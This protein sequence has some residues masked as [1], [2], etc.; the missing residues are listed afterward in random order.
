V[1]NALE[2]ALAAQ[3]VSEVQPTALE[4]AQQVRAPSPEEGAPVQQNALE[5]ALSA[6]FPEAPGFAPDEG[7]SIY[8]GGTWKRA[9]ERGGAQTQGLYGQFLRELGESTGFAGLVDVGDEYVKKAFLEAVRNP[10]PFEGL[11]DL[12][13]GNAGQFVLNAIGEQVYNLGIAA[14]G[15]AAATLTFGTTIPGSLTWLTARAALGKG[16]ASTLAKYLPKHALM[17]KSAAGAL[18]GFGAFL[19]INTGEIIQEQIDAGLDPDLGSSLILGVPSSALEMVGITSFTAPLF[20]GF[21]KEIAEGA[22]RTI[23]K[24]FGHASISGLIGEGGTEAAQEALVIASQ[25]LKDPTFDVE[26]AITSSEGLKRMIFSGVSGA[27]VGGALGGAGGIARGGVDVLRGRFQTA[28]LDAKTKAA[29]QQWESAVEPNSF[30]DIKAARDA[31]V[32]AV[33]PIKEATNQYLNYWKK[34]LKGA[35]KGTKDAGV[36][37]SVE[38]LVKAEQA[39][40]ADVE[41]IES[42]RATIAQVE[43]RS[44]S[45]IDAIENILAQM[46]KVTKNRTQAENAKVESFQKQTLKLLEAVDAA[47]GEAKAKHIPALIELAKK[48]TQAGM[49][50]A[51][52]IKKKYVTDVLKAISKATTAF[53]A[54]KNNDLN[55]YSKELDVLA[56]QLAHI[57]EQFPETTTT[58]EELQDQDTGADRT[59]SQLQTTRKALY[60][61]IKA[62]LDG[63]KRMAFAQGWKE[64]PES[65]ENYAKSENLKAQLTEKGVEIVHQ[66]DDFNAAREAEFPTKKEDLQDAVG[67]RIEDEGQE[68]T[69]EATE[70][71]VEAVAGVTSRR[72]VVPTPGRTAQVEEISA[73]V[74]RQATERLEEVEAQQKDVIELRFYDNEG[75]LLETKYALPEEHQL[76]EGETSWVDESIKSLQAKYAARGIEGFVISNRDQN[77]DRLLKSF[78]PEWKDLSIYHGMYK[79]IWDVLKKVR[80]DKPIIMQLPPSTVIWRRPKRGRPSVAHALKPYITVQMLRDD[81]QDAA[82]IEE[83]LWWTAMKNWDAERVAE[84]VRQ[85]G[86]LFEEQNRM[87]EEQLNDALNGT[88]GLPAAQLFT[89]LF[90]KPHQ[91]WGFAAIKRKDGKIQRHNILT[92]ITQLDTGEWKTKG[93]KDAY[94]FKSKKELKEAVAKQKE[95][96]KRYGDNHTVEYLDAGD[97]RCRRRHVGCCAVRTE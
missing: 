93:G 51:N 97:G 14:G 73:A 79:A 1:A 53:A 21:S 10:S 82:W 91:I 76:P 71:T 89:K 4:I 86:M 20:R 44:A 9:T 49:A 78:P 83:R 92:E 28:D 57:R 88:S 84:V 31:V 34:N 33:T 74:S 36:A 13:F 18:G 47:K 26:A 77:H 85:K 80:K 43:A 3:P 58:A 35:T 8:R 32:E 38:E 95:R 2:K 30:L 12:R 65:L 42:G 41:Q 15:A 75:R 27:V 19:P 7:P 24:R 5:Q 54:K 66:E 61:A 45:V 96:M 17:S 48:M 90:D 25:K 11:E 70:R 22:I 39:V 6:E 60:T 87:F 40:A 81:R 50:N 67:V 94:V 59:E 72:G 56:T 69:T 29:E 63:T 52:Q 64:L 46:P 62:V 16:A 55:K 37:A 68:V 23:L